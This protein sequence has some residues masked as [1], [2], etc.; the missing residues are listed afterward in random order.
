MSERRAEAKCPICARAV[1]SDAASFPFC[2]PRC[3]LVDLG[4]WIDGRYAIPG[5]SAADG[6]LVESDI[7]VPEDSGTPRA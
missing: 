5:A 6:P 7:D 2:T 4:N 1:A 3:K